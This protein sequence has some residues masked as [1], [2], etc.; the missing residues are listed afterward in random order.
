MKDKPNPRNNA[1]KEPKKSVLGI[2]FCKEEKDKTYFPELKDQWQS[3]E[4]KDRLKF[5]LGAIIGLILFVSFL[6]LVF[7]ALN[8]M[9]G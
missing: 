9:R 1:R 6:V 4:R 5:V 8:A 2:F 7:L 3:M